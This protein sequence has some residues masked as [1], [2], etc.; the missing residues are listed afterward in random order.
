VETVRQSKLH[1]VY[2]FAVT[3][4][5]KTELFDLAMRLQPDKL[6]S[7]DYAGSDYVVYPCVN[8]SEVTDELLAAYMYKAFPA[9]FTNPSRALRIVRDFP[10]PLSVWKYYQG[11]FFALTRVGRG[12]PRLGR[13]AT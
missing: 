4:Y 5:P 2:P 3:P 7:I 9:L 8:L 6:A 12:K 13:G 1:V 10:R 11:V